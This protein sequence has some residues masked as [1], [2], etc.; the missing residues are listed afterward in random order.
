MHVMNDCAAT[1]GS[2]FNLAFDPHGSRLLQNACGPFDECPLEL[3][4]GVRLPG[5]KVWALPFSAGVQ[6][7]PYLEHFSTL[8]T[9]EYR[10]VQ[11][12][13]GISFSMRLR[14]PFYP[15][16]AELSTAPFYYVD[17]AVSRLGKWRGQGSDTPLTGGQIVFALAGEGVQFRPLEHGF[18]YEFSSASTVQTDT[19]SSHKA[20]PVRSSVYSPDGVLAGDSELRV[21]FDLD[22]G[23]P[24]TLSLVWCC[25]SEEPQLE[26]HG[27]P[28][29]F[30]YHQFFPSEETMLSWALENR[31]EVEERCEFLDSLF[32]DWSLGRAASNLTALALHS[33]LANTWW[34]TRKGDKDW[35]SVWEGSRYCH[36]TI[37]VEYNDA[38]LYFALWPQLLDMLLAQWADLEVDARE[39]HGPEAKGTS[40]LGHDM[41]AG[42]FAGQQVYPHPTEVEGNADYLLLL[43]ARTFF[44]GD[45][46][47]ARRLAPLCRR[48]A[49]FVVNCDTDGN[50]FPDTGTANAVGDVG[51]AVQS[52][53]EQTFLAVK[54]QAAL[55][56]AAELEELASGGKGS[57]APRWRAFASKGVKTLSEKA[58]LGDHFAVTL[59]RS[60]EGAGAIPTGDV[61]AAEAPAGWDDY[62][63]HTANGLLYLFLADIKMPRWPHT[64]LAEDIE[65]AERATRAPY[66][67]GH[68]GSGECTAWVSQSLWRDYVA[69]YLGVDMAQNVEAYWDYQI[70]A[71][72]NLGTSMFVDASPERDLSFSPRGATVFGLALSAAGLRL[73]RVAG[74]VHL[75]PVRS[76]LRAP[77]LPLVDWAHM[78]A[79]WL[80]V[81][82][83]DGVAVARITECD[84]LGDLSVR[85]TGAER[86]TT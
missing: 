50:G 47:L 61:A 18:G 14:A 27:G 81:Q 82:C 29:P 49:E 57:K 5:G 8:T 34:T 41:G 31:A 55:W 80:E 17:L 22:C 59:D 56:A 35:F 73:N 78:R 1:L 64:R 85:V 70:L 58:W 60:A 84:L 13:L 74:E 44:T 21:G 45:V 83:R 10:G 39:L 36:S 79:P 40:L 51:A 65:A 67:S 6:S 32:T 75:R 68:T 76:T 11:P 54:A 66:G 63:I 71:G 86:E 19:V 7:F 24:A 33:F 9:I 30:K 48:L 28:T 3:V 12:D 26:V 53:Q 15:Q 52:G 20:A 69:A 23:E 77:L 25:W 62:S 43:A 4:V 46:E 37:D 72:D 2:R 42:H 16:D 38:L